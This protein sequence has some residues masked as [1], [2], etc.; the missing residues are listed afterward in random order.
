MEFFS[1][2]FL[3]WGYLWHLKLGDFFLELLLEKEKETSLRT[4][5]FVVGDEVWG[6]TIIDHLATLGHLGVSE[7]AWILSFL[8]HVIDLFVPDKLLTEICVVE[9][10]IFFIVSKFLGCLLVWLPVVTVLGSL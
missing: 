8:H 2:C 7:S 4:V 1:S 6:R 10:I 3:G 9:T 5:Y